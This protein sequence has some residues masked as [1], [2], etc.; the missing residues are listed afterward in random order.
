M[1]RSLPPSILWRRYFPTWAQT[2]CESWGALP[3]SAVASLLLRTDDIGPQLAAANSMLEIER[4]TLS[5]SSA[6]VTLVVRKE[7]VEAMP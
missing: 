6:L 2:S 3:S 5:A 7:D 1:G 4:G